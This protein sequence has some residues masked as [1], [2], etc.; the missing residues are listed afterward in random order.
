MKWRTW[1]ATSSVVR[2][3]PALSRDCRRQRS[4][5]NGARV[6]GGTV[7]NVHATPTSREEDRQAAWTTR[8]E[9]A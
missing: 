7:E 6:E 8:K 2:C 1:M 5:A 9:K 3:S 4:L